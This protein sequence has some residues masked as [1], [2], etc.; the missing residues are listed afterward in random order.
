MLDAGVFVLHA[1]EP[2]WVGEQSKGDLYVY[3]CRGKA[4][5]KLLK[6]LL[7]VEVDLELS[8]MF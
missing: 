5:S 2:V 1:A 6:N 8:E 3:F 7:S 4:S